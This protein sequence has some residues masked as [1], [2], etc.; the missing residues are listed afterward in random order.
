M[1]MEPLQPAEKVAIIR[2]H[3]RKSKKQTFVIQGF[4]ANGADLAAWE[5]IMESR[6]D[7]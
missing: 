1:V 3:M 6:V 2:E 5:S 7:F 4:P